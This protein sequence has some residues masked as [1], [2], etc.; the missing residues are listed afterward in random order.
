[1]RKCGNKIYKK[2]LNPLMRRKFVN[3][4]GYN[5]VWFGCSGHK[6]GAKMYIW[7]EQKRKLLKMGMGWGHQSIYGK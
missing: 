5:C 2:G 4:R 3:V 1:M 6:K 7:I